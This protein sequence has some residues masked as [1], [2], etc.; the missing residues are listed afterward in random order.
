MSLWSRLLT[1]AWQRWPISIVLQIIE[2][3]CFLECSMISTLLHCWLNPHSLALFFSLA[4][5]QRR[6]RF[7]NQL[8][9]EAS[10]SWAPLHIWYAIHHPKP[11]LNQNV[12]DDWFE[13][14]S[15]ASHLRFPFFQAPELLMGKPFNERVDVYAFWIVLWEILTRENPFNGMSQDIIFHGVKSGSLKP[16]IPDDCPQEYS[17]LINQCLHVTPSKRP[18]FEEIVNRL[19]QM[20][21]PTR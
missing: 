21:K 13:T 18:N 8:W 20:M 10:T 19:K 6:N 5:S 11:I 15:L 4:R 9:L 16:Q 1:L 14:F 2:P 17:D 3:C 12:L 7:R